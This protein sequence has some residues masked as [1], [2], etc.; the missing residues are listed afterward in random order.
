MVKIAAF[1]NLHHISCLSQH[2]GVSLSCQA[3]HI[4][5][6]IGLHQHIP[7]RILMGASLS[8]DATFDL[9]VNHT[10]TN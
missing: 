3:A 6:V 1:V 10:A 2:E 7:L 8:I 4:C 5:L 9:T